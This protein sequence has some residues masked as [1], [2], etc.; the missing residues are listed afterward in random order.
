MAGEEARE[1]A[2]DVTAAT[3][4]ASRLPPAL[5][6]RDFRLYW[7]GQFV[8]TTGSQ[9]QS[10]AVAWQV[11]LLTNSAVA[12]GMIGLVRVVPIIVLSL[13]GGVVADA[14]D[15]RRLLIA[16]QTT[17]MSLSILLAVTTVSGHASIWLI[18]A[19]TGL[20][21]A[22]IS[23]D[24]PAR[25]A[26]IPSLVTRE[27]L[28]NAISVNTT[29][30]GVAIVVGPSVAGLVIAGGGVAAV[31]ALDAFSFLAVIIAL[32]RI[33][34]PPVSGGLQRVSLVAAVEGLRFMRASPV[35][36]WTMLLDFVATFFGSAQALLPIFARH[37]LA[38]GSV[39]YGILYA[40]PSVGA[41]AGGAVMSI[42]GSRIRRP[43]RTILVAVAAY[44]AFT[45]GFGVSRT[46][47]LSLLALAGTGA[48]DTVSLVLRQT[49]RQLSTPDAL[50]G[51]MT[52]VSM[53]FFMGGPQL[54]E[55]EAGVVAR[56]IGAPGSVVLGG[57]AAVIA[58]AIIASRAGSLRRYVPLA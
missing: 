56:A 14:L 16:T 8:S 38:V 26:M 17:L 25:Q 57:L 42:V 48:A 28:T 21:S 3:T 6:F 47:A 5:R 4:R 20:A 35:L 1:E 44:G 7:S 55:V 41:L 9:M 52:S 27:H 19:F 53:I 51:R 10:A 18:Y 11:Y 39:G 50:R 32:L 54:G 37:I 15:R 29:T 36:L 43:G 40:S 22:A 30:F 23:F 2:P 46:F 45:I 12:L 13:F 34:P 31:Y 24:N 58:T 49:V 33:H